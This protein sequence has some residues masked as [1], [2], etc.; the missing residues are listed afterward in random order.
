VT[1]CG[2]R[3]ILQPAE[4]FAVAPFATPIATGQVT[5]VTH[6][7]AVSG[8][9]ACGGHR[10]ATFATP[11]ASCRVTIQP[12]VRGRVRGSGMRRHSVA[13]FATPIASCVGTIYA[14]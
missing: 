4:D 10:P 5:M 9:A 14:L 3:G 6:V 8:D 13:T 2:I 11:I 7:T 1:W 12:A